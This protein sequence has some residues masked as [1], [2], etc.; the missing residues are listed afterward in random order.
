MGIPGEIEIKC[1]ESL[2]GDYFKNFN[3]EEVLADHPFTHPLTFSRVIDG[4][5]L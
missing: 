1:F 2:R 5:E 3:D 4:C